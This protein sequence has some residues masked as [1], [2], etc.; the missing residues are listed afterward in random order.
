MGVAGVASQ[1]RDATLEHNGLLKR[2]AATPTGVFAIVVHNA[3]AVR[4]AAADFKTSDAHLRLLVPVSRVLDESVTPC[5]DKRCHR[6][7]PQQ[8]DEVNGEQ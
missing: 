5:T 1:A 2:V 7:S 3:A 4:G 8:S 6:A